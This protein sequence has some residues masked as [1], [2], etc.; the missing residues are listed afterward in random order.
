MNMMFT[1]LDKKIRMLYDDKMELSMKVHDKIFSLVFP[2]G[3]YVGQY[4]D[5]SAT[6]LIRMA[7]KSNITEDSTIL[8]IGSGP[9]GPACFLASKI[10][11]KVIG[12]DI[13]ANHLEYARKRVE[14]MSLN[15][16][17]FIE[18]SVWEIDLP[19]NKFDAIIG[20]GAWCH[21][22]SK[23]LF[24]LVYKW[25]KPG[26][27]IAFMERIKIGDL[28]DDEMH[29]LCSEW[30]CPTIETITS[31]F[32]LLYSSGFNDI[33]FEDLTEEYKSILERCIDT[34]LS[35]KNE[36][37]SIADDNFFE[38]DLKL[39]NYE[40]KAASSNK[41]GYSMFIGKKH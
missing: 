33:Y 1:E 22:N 35:I 34:R 11:C 15:N 23:Y 30:A 32:E 20:T 6:D 27:T 25:L 10:G 16:V 29:E 2:N 38:E 40:R 28:S 31:Y 12:I 7:E 13:S 4:S 21:L 18:A 24:P 5:N 14:H 17:E 36:I 41:L 3:E 37:I 8:D 19:N 9:G 39:A 26:G